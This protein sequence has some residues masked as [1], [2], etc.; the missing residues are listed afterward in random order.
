ME[1]NG[2]GGHVISGILNSEFKIQ[3]VETPQDTSSFLSSLE[4]GQSGQSGL[5]CSCSVR[6]CDCDCDCDCDFHG[7]SGSG[8]SYIRTYVH[9]Y[10]RMCNG[11]GDGALLEINLADCIVSY[12]IGLCCVV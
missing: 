6:L 12:W 7:V 4:P 8:S 1:W 5:V 2:N 3:A 9:A 11:G 10:I